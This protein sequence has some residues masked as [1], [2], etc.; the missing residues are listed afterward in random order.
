MAITESTRCYIDLPEVELRTYLKS[1]KLEDSEQEC[2]VQA[3]LFTHRTT[4]G[5]IPSVEIK[6]LFEALKS[7]PQSKASFRPYANKGLNFFNNLLMRWETQFLLRLMKDEGS[8]KVIF[9]NPEFSLVAKKYQDHDHEKAFSF[10][11]FKDLNIDKSLINIQSYPLKDIDL[12]TLGKYRNQKILLDI[13]IEKY[14][15]FLL[16]AG[17]WNVAVQHS[18]KNLSDFLDHSIFRSVFQQAVNKFRG[19]PE[20]KNMN[21]SSVRK[22]LKAGMTALPATFYD[23]FMFTLL[24]GMKNSQDFQEKHLLEISISIILHHTILREATLQ[25][26]EKNERLEYAYQNFIHILEKETQPIQKQTLLSL[27]EREDVQSLFVFDPDFQSKWPKTIEHLL[28][29]FSYH[30]TDEKIKASSFIHVMHHDQ[31]AYIMSGRL[32]KH[33]LQSIDK[34][35]KH[36]KEELIHEIQSLLYNDKQELFLTSV[37]EM[38]QKLESMIAHEDHLVHYLLLNPLLLY[39]LMESLMSSLEAKRVEKEFFEERSSRRLPLYLCLDLNPKQLTEEAKQSFSFFQKIWLFF[40]L[41]RSKKLLQKPANLKNR[42]GSTHRIPDP[43]S[44]SFLKKRYLKNL[45]N[46]SAVQAKL[47]KLNAEWNS[48][49]GTQSTALQHEIKDRADHAIQAIYSLA[50]T[51]ANPEE[52]EKKTDSHIMAIVDKFQK[53]CENTLAL[54]H[55]LEVY[56]I[57]AVTEELGK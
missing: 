6:D 31:D 10:P 51:D 49:E 50:Q 52:L 12:E 25:E 54:R 13:E 14:G 48:L 16:P 7:N 55:Y 26:Q 29:R 46:Q 3:A 15:S 45:Q 35:K 28:E 47:N 22:D 39:E 19:M 57:S 56:V 11:Q 53:S 8:D 18:L 2:L 17:Y 23:R 32:L 38:E 34:I 9:I 33:F 24:S 1:F 27:I 36:L 41:R 21:E 42:H 43:A 20:Y 44:K 40:V 5:P 30:E 4:D 37:E